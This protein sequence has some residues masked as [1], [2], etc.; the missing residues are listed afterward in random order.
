VR[1]HA[2]EPTHVVVLARQNPPRPGA[3]GRRGRRRPRARPAVSQPPPAAVRTTRATLIAAQPFA[4]DGEAAYW[5]GRVDGEREVASALAALNGL[6]HLHRTATA[7]PSVREVARRQA[8][9]VRVGIGAGEEVAKGRWTRAIELPPPPAPPRRSAALR[10]DERLAAL[11]S[12]RDA[13]LACEELAI[14][15]RADVT[16]GRHREAALQLEVALAAALRE[17]TPWAPRGDLAARIA[18]LRDLEP[19]AA[20]AA[21]AAL[22]GGLDDGATADVERAL[23]RLEAALRARSVVGFD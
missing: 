10:P 17:L 20:A 4:D 13:A 9:A 15:A 11:L 22:E 7:D 3:L 2:G 12:G 5:L 16:A 21:A 18:E 1:G 14:R 19:G 6:L 23:R 8:I